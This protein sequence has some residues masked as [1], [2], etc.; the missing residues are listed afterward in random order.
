[1][2]DQLIN[3]GKELLSGKLSQSVGF[4]GNQIDDTLE[5]A[6]ESTLDGLKEQVLG[7][8]ISGVMDLFNGKSETTTSNPIVGGIAAK[9]VSGLISKLG[10]NQ[11]IAEKATEIVIPF[12][13]SKF[14]SSQ[15][16][17][18][19]DGNQLMSMLG[20][21]SDG[22]VMGM[23]GGVLG[24]KNEDNPLGKLGKLF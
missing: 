17:E 14:G 13:M 23:L 2:I 8:N 4:K 18:A 11:S 16:G 12:I 15:T 3:Q 10:V 5:I 21:D 24:N 7:G 1:M 19:K 6:K 20:M 22:G 9:M